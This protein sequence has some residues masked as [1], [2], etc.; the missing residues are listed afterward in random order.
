M[1]K[2]NTVRIHDE[3]ERW[4]EKSPKKR[5]MGGDFTIRKSDRV[6]VHHEKE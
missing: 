6:K 1:R 3:K 4:G 2:S 5:A